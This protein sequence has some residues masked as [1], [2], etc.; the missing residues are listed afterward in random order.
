MTE[1]TGKFSG[2]FRHFVQKYASGYCAEAMSETVLEELLQIG[3]NAG[4]GKPVQMIKQS[5][6]TTA[7]VTELSNGER[8]FVK[9]TNSYNFKRRFR[10]LLAVPRPLR[11]LRTTLFLENLGVKVPEIRL[12]T[13]VQRN[14][15]KL[16]MVVNAAMP[17]PMTMAEQAD[18]VFTPEVFPEF[19][20]KMANLVDLIHRH[21]LVHGDLKMQNILLRQIDGQPELGLFDFDGSRFFRHKIPARRR[22]KEYARVV[23]SLAKIAGKSKPELTAKAI[24]EQLAMYVQD[25][26]AQD[27]L[28]FYMDKIS[29]HKERYPEKVLPE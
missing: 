6:G 16:Q 25:D 26:V 18:W 23:T 10:Q 19:C 8:V 1:Y 3:G 13:P 22:A 17:Q 21:N 20:R 9:L 15:G 11:V 28:N 7:F 29:G 24:W 4:A 14:W 5:K 27:F 12:V 2:A